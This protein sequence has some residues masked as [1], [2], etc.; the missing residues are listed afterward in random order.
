MYL[1]LG[2]NTAI[3][4]KNVVAILD[5]DNVTVNKNGRNFFNTAQKQGNVVYVTDELPKS[6]VVCEDNGK[7]I[8]YISQLS[9]VTLQKRIKRRKP[10]KYL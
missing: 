5:L 2:E 8:V 10:R 6:A 3:R 4:T 1:H 9:P 7:K